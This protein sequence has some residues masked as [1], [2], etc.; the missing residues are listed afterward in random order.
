[1]THDDGRV[2]SERIRIK[3]IRPDTIPVT[4]LPFDRQTD[5]AM[6]LLNRT[7]LKGDAEGK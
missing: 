1:M 5:C 6:I 3:Y 4:G 7:V 2:E